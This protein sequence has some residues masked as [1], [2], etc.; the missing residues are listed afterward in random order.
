MPIVEVSCIDGEM[1]RGLKDLDESVENPRSFAIN[2]LHSTFNLYSLHFSFFIYSLPSFLPCLTW[3]LLSLLLYAVYRLIVYRAPRNGHLLSVKEVTSFQNLNSLT[4][5]KIQ[6]AAI[7]FLF[8]SVV[9]HFISLP[10]SPANRWE[11]IIL[12]APASDCSIFHCL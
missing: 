8:Q 3:I 10:W 5:Y 12:P 9:Y 11:T 2:E 1:A 6:K 7:P 4:D